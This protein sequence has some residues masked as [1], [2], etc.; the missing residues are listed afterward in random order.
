MRPKAGL[1]LMLLQ[2]HLF[3]A[4]LLPVLTILLLVVAGEAA[5]LVIVLVWRVAVELVD[6]ELAVYQ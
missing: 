2:Q 6:L 4:F 5:A 3:Q 1:A